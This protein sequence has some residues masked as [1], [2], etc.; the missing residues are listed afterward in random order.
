MTDF[1]VAENYRRSWDP[2]HDAWTKRGDAADFAAFLA[3]ELGINPKGVTV[4]KDGKMHRVMVPLLSAY[5]CPHKSDTTWDEHFRFFKVE[6]R[7]WANS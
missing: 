3:A 1:N 4:E 2:T 6:I 7:R 5:W